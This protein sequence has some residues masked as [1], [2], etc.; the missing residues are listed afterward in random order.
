MLHRLPLLALLVLS[1]APTALSLQETA[2]ESESGHRYPVVIRAVAKQ[3]TEEAKAADAKA[4]EAKEPAQKE[5]K[6]PEL[7]LLGLA[8]REKTIF[9][10]N[11]YS[12]VLYVDRA[13]AKEELAGYKGMKRSKLEKQDALFRKLLTQ[14][15]TKELRLRFCRDVDTEDIVSAFEDSL[16]PRMLARMKRVKGTE[17]QKLATLTKFRGFFTLD[18]LEKGNELRFTWHP[19]G[20]LS[21]VVNGVR[22]PD[23]MAPELCASLF[24]V[25]LGSD[26][27]SNSGKKK[28]V[29]RLPDLLARLLRD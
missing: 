29:R 17:Q 3:A 20:T 15:T 11:V 6:R 7:D 2:K 9:N 8:I 10:V 25:Y 16:K 22:K 5:E 27:I 23:L 4:E 13:F 19:D 24:D 18:E 28:L 12:Y 21:T 14:N 1:F 26:P